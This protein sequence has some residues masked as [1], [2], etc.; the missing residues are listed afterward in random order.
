MSYFTASNFYNLKTN[1]NFYFN[2]ICEICCSRSSSLNSLISDWKISCNNLTPA[3]GRAATIQW[4][5]LLRHRET[6]NFSSPVGDNGYSS[7][8]LTEC[9]IYK[10]VFIPDSLWLDK[11]LWCELSSTDSLNWHGD[12]TTSRKNNASRQVLRLCQRPDIVNSVCGSL[13]R[14][15][16]CITHTPYNAI[17]VRHSVNPCHSLLYAE[18]VYKSSV[19]FPIQIFYIHGAT[20]K[21]QYKY[22]T[23]TALH[24]YCNQRMTHKLH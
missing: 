9:K 7:D 8:T 10:T 14:V 3:G 16:F 24:W 23:S 11:T 15:F 21:R 6:C 2:V 5:L 1:G 17:Y 12:F 20:R 18:H 19:L 4:C 13:W 22:F